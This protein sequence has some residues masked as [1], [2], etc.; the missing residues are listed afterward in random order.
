VLPGLD[1]LVLPSEFEGHPE[2]ILEAISC[3]V[4]CL[5]SDVGGCAETIRDDQEGYILR[6]NTSQG[7][8]GCVRR[9][10]GSNDLWQ[11]MSAQCRLRHAEQFTTEQM[12]ARWERLYL[13]GG[14]PASCTAPPHRVGAPVDREEIRTP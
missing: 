10:V 4:P 14:E 6:E 11:H 12:A 5:C 2:V 1:L 8:A 3:G 7:I 13:T 9:L